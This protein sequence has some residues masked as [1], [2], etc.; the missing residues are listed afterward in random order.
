[1]VFDVWAICEGISMLRVLILISFSYYIHYYLSPS[2]VLIIAGTHLLV[3]WHLP[4]KWEGEYLLGLKISFE[5]ILTKFLLYQVLWCE[6]CWSVYLYSYIVFCRAMCLLL[7]VS[8][9]SRFRYQIMYPTRM[10]IIRLITCNTAN[11]F[12]PY[13]YSG[14]E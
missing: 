3:F 12:I 7:S 14:L 1:M 13:R 4:E 11:T 8:I 6:E 5:L 10:N 9:D 2:Y